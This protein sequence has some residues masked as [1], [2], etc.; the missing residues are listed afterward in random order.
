MR[1][2]SL[3]VIFSVLMSFSAVVCA[4]ENSQ[5]VPKCELQSLAEGKSFDLASYAGKVV[6]LDFWASWCGPCLQSMPFMQSLQ[7]TFQSK[8]LQVVT[9]N[10]DENPEDAKSFISQHGVNLPVVVDRSG[11]CAGAFQVSAMPSSFLI[12][13]QGRIRHVE[14]GF[15]LEDREAITRRVTALLAE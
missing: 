4:A 10:V 5:A 8:G 12:D 7:Q 11:E 14:A 13:R 3:S 15:H 6:Y 1:R 2:M 9:L